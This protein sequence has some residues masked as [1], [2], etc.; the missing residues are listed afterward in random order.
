MLTIPSG[1]FMTIICFY[2]WRAVTFHEIA[3]LIS[4]L[5]YARGS[6]S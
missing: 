1:S 4:K 2:E 6:A 5:L 3:E